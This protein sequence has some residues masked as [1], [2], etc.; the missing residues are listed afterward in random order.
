MKKKIAILGSTGSIGKTLVK[1]IKK[2]KNK[3]DIILLTG[4]KNY[5]TLLLQAKVLKPK[6]III[7]NKV[8]YLKFLQ[9]NKNK[10]INVYNDFNSYKDI[11][12]NKIDYTMSSITGLNGLVPTLKVI[13]FTKEI[14][15]ANKEALIC[16]WSILKKELLK[17]N[18]KFL[19]VD[20]EHFSI[21][22]GLKDNNDKVSKI[23]ITASGG[24][25]YD[26][27]I[28]NFNKI[29]V[30]Q[31]LKHPNWKMGK[32]I[33]I[34]S[35]TMMNKVFEIIE[36]KNIFELNY[37]DLRILIHPKSY[38]HAIIQFKNGM[39]KII[40]HDTN[41]IIPIF[42]TLYSKS[43]KKIKSKD[44]RIDI[45]NNLSLKKV[46]LKRFPLV[47]ILKYLPNNHSLYETLVVSINDTLVNLFL[48][49]KINFTDISKKFIELIKLKEFNKY[50]KIRPNKIRDII[51]LDQ[52]VRLKILT[53]HV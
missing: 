8:S 39:S 35:A 47:N 1:I 25:F 14:A 5:K 41:M 52:L 33:S 10:K 44:L 2:E 49:G 36:A 34:D 18:T 22:Y 20:S 32:K 48:D 13:K 23:T 26:Y 4:N 46:N 28:K 53:K 6:N 50:K 40:V 31:A 9:I 42:N 15:I 17:F 19:P 16:G 24:P 7:T 45:L 11:F 37:K 29:K 3:F 38:V 43:N 30:K 51:N 21:W 12:K 27:P